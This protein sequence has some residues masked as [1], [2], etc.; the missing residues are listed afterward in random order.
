MPADQEANESSSFSARA[1]AWRHE[2][3]IDAAIDALTSVGCIGFNMDSIAARVGVSKGTLYEH[4]GSRDDLI[5]EVLMR[6]TEDVEI[7]DVPEVTTPAAALGQ[8]LDALYRGTERGGDISSPALPCCLRVSPCPHGWTDRWQP[9]AV[10]FGLNDPA[11]VRLLGEALQ[12]LAAVPSFKSLS[13]EGHLAEVRSTLGRL[14][15]SYF[16]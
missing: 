8:A 12:A 15:A 11:D 13:K 4:A 9:I 16:A 3:I 14:L 7:P 5:A 10:A 6:W 1:R 2:A